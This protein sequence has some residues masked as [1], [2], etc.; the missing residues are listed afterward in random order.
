[1]TFSG[2]GGGGEE[3]TSENRKL[4]RTESLGLI[5]KTPTE[6][7][8]KIIQIAQGAALATFFET[9]AIV[10]LLAGILIEL[11]QRSQLLTIAL[12]HKNSPN[13]TSVVSYGTTTLLQKASKL[14]M[15]IW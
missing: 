2:G 6:T 11:V 4:V 14:T 9:A 5:V 12:T 10:S 1:M 15:M 3:G 7:A 13:V 8:E